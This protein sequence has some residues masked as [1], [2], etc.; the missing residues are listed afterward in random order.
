MSPL[1]WQE[2]MQPLH[3]LIDLQSENQKMMIVI[4]AYHAGKSRF[5]ASLTAQTPVA[6][7]ASDY[8]G[9]EAPRQLSSLEFG[10]GKRLFLVEWPGAARSDTLEAALGDFVVGFVVIFDRSSPETFRETRSILE[11]HESRSH[12]PLVIAANTLEATKAWDLDDVRV[13]LHLTGGNVLTACDAAQYHSTAAVIL[14]LTDLLPDTDFTQ[15]LKK[16]LSMTKK[17]GT[18]SISTN[19]SKKRRN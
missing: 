8:A 17:T 18:S 2:N 4:G 12:L 1:F 9:Y 6:A 3:K 13:A 5:I 16:D 7:D 14:K 19:G 11:S 15:Q 10:D